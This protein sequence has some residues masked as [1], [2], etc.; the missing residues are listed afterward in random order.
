MSADNKAIGARL[1]AAREEPPYWTRGDLARLLRRAAAPGELEHVAHVKSLIDMIKQW[2]AGAWLP[3]PRY[4]PLY[5]RVLK[6]TEDELFGSPHA[7]PP[8]PADDRSVAAEEVE[9]LDLA[10][11]AGATDLAAGTLDLLDTVVDRLCRDYPTVSPEVLSRRGKAHLSYVLHLLNSRTTLAEHRELLVRSGWLSVLL[12]CTLYDAGDKTGAEILRSTARRLGEQAGHGEIVGWSWEIAAWFAL[13]ERRYDE[14]VEY[15]EAGIQHAGASNAAVQLTLQ[16]GR[17]YA[18]MGDRRAID[19]LRVGRA[20]MDQLPRPGHP[21][22]HFVFD[23]DKYEFYCS[24]IYTMLGENDAAEEHAREVIVQSRRPDDSVRWPM[25][26]AMVNLDLGLVAGRR[27]DLESAVRHGQ[28][29]LGPARRSGDL[30]PRANEL[31]SRLE[32]RYPRERRV[33]E[34]AEQLR[35]E[36]REL[37]PD[38]GGLALL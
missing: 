1:R 29:A 35:D 20:I 14:V 6:T 33:A 30:L 4:R 12:A 13:V 17:G 38:E 25:R 24:T 18:R 26:Y 23:H 27:G 5:A 19:A 16:A 36:G 9:L 7:Q 3:G 15:S 28:A 10:A 21:E 31:R 2:E 34:F 32:D 37:P 22:H 8:M 11:H